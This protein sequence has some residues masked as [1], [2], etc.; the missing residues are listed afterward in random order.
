MRGD[1]MDFAKVPIGFGMAL[2]QN[3]DAM[4]IY[5]AM[6]DS[7]REAILSRAHGARS[8]REMEQIVAS[9]ARFR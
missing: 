9:I 7:E 1:R 4:K 2:A 3:E 5:A 6:T 8:E